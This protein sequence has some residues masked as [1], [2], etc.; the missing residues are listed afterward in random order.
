VTGKR[1]KS[2]VVT[3]DGLIRDHRRDQHRRGLQPSTIDARARAV[4]LF[5]RWLEPAGLLEATTDQVERFL[6]GRRIAAKARYTYISN[7]H[8]FYAWAVHAGRAELDP[9]VDIIQPR[10]HPG[11]PRPIA[12]ADLGQALAMA[13]PLLRVILAGAAL[14]GMRCC[15]LARLG[16]DDIRDDLTPPVIIAR[17]K[18]AKPRTIPLHPDVY[19]ALLDLGL[20]RVGPV[21]HRPDGRAMPA[22]KVS[23]LANRY[24]HG[25]GIAATVHQCRH[26]F[27]T[28]LY[29]TSKRDLL[30]VR[31]LMGH[32][33]IAT[34]TVYA[35]YDRAGAAEAVEAL[36]P[37]RG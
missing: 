25:L 35:A 8:V 26:W 27:G 15:E 9:T 23:H 3:Y 22:W 12:D 16:R 29:R 7:L 13:D 2:E 4:R 34:T 31:D 1:S 19:Q 30:L 18:G 5:A 6:D 21:L 10:L 33:N 24:L 32:A 20:P 14:E 17:G 36:T 37:G 11:S 28:S